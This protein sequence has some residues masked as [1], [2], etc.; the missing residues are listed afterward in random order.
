VK[1]LRIA[2]IAF[3]Y[4]VEN[5][6]LLPWRYIHEVSKQLLKLN[7]EMVVITDGYP[8]LPRKN[9]IE[10]VPV[11]RLRHVKH[12]PP[13][14]FDEIAATVARIDPD[15]VL[16][17]MG[18]TSFFQRRL[19]ER[20]EYPIVAL[21]ES[22]VHW[23]HEIL[24]NIGITEISR[25][26]G[27]L[28]T[29]LAGSFF[30]R[31]F[32]RETFN[33]ESIR[34]VIAV[35]RENK[36]RLKLI[37]VDSHKLVYIP[38]GVDPN[39]LQAPSR[40]EVYKARNDAS[41]DHDQFLVTYFGPPLSI[42]GVNTLIRATKFVLEKAPYLRYHL[43]VLILSRRRGSEYDA[44]EKRLLK[45]IG[46]F[47]LDRIVRLK[48]G[49][50]SEDKVKAFIAASDLVAL[51]FRHVI[52]EV[53]LA[54]M[55][56]LALGKPVLSTKVDGIPEL[57]EDGRGLV[58]EPHDFESLGEIIIYFSENTEK[59]KQYGERARRYILNHSTWEDCARKMLAFL[60][61]AR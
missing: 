46:R 28:T 53:P 48:S 54:V 35:S 45:L 44:H 32:I 33:S 47:D 22:P 19:F 15:V 25:E 27:L 8:E 18:L 37:G 13:R 3:N 1:A 21:V 9:S 40:K 59:L 41:V 11:I 38:P 17:L 34:K 20:L 23:R 49:F 2:L 55:E 31:F 24:R 60:E 10:N 26:A 12:F 43:R 16:W 30:P 61:S 57:L 52:S 7:H 39:S 58:I 5:L 6:R 14:D 29:S 36:N 51:P 50:Q 56:A 4:R 42:R